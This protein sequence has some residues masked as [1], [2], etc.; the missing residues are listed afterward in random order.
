MSDFSFDDEVDNLKA[1][2]DTEE[3]QSPGL[4]KPLAER[5]ALKSA[6][7]SGDLSV[8][9]RA[10][11][12]LSSLGKSSILQDA[13]DL[14]K[15]DLRINKREKVKAIL[16]NTELSPIEQEMQIQALSEEVEEQPKLDRSVEAALIED[17]LSNIDNESPAA[18]TNLLNYL[19]D[20]SD[21]LQKTIDK[22]V[23]SMAKE[24]DESAPW[25]VTE[26][27]VNSLVPG[28]AIHLGKAIDQAMPGVLD[29]SD[30]IFAGESLKKFRT[31]MRSK[32]AEERSE[33]A[34]KLVK[35]LIDNTSWF[36]TD[37]LAAVQNIDMIL[38][39]L[40]PSLSE[41]DFERWLN[42]LFSVLDVLPGA[43]AVG[44][45]LHGK[46][47]ARLLKG[48]PSE[49][50]RKLS[51]V[52][53]D[54]V[55]N[56]LN[57]SL[58]DEEFEKVINTLGMTRQDVIDSYVL[59][60]AAGSNIH[61]GPTLTD[62]LKEDVIKKT[63]GAETFGINYK[64]VEK[65]SSQ[66][67]IEREIENLTTDLGVERLSLTEIIPFTGG[68]E[69]RVAISASNT[70]GFTSMD[71]ARAVALKYLETLPDESNIQYFKANHN[72]GNFD[73]VSPLS[74][75]KGQYLFTIALKHHYNPK[76][77]G[78]FHNDVTGFT[79]KPAAY[80][81]MSSVFNRWMVHAINRSGDQAEV[82]KAELH[83]ILQPMIKLDRKNQNVLL[84]VLD[85][86]DANQEWFDFNTLVSKLR[87][88]D[89]PEHKIP[90]IVEGYHA[91]IRFSNRTHELMND[92]VRK[93]LVQDG[94]KRVLLKT[95]NGLEDSIGKITD[96]AS[97]P[98]DVKEV[99]VLGN[100]AS[101][102]INTRLDLK[103]LANQG[104][105]FIKL[106]SPKRFPGANGSYHY[107]ALDL[108][109]EGKILK[110]P[111]QVLKRQE[112]YVPR[113]YDA[114]YIVKVKVKGDTVD[115][116][117]SEHF[118]TL[119]IESNIGD[120]S[121]A[122]D[123]L[124]KRE[125][126]KE[127]VYVLAKEQKDLEYIS[128]TSLDYFRDSGRLF[129][130]R[131]TPTEFSTFLGKRIVKSIGDSYEEAVNFASKHVAMD[132]LIKSM[133]TRWENTY[134]NTLP[135]VKEFPYNTKDIPKPDNPELHRAWKD[136]VAIKDRINHLAGLDEALSDRIIN[137]AINYTATVIAG[138]GKSDIFNQI[139]AA[140]LK[141][142]KVAN[143]IKIAKNLAF[144]R[145]IVLEPQKQIAMQA[146][147]ASIM[148][149]VDYGAKYFL[150]KGMVDFQGLAFGLALDRKGETYKAI[151]P[152]LAK[153]MGMSV[154]DYEILVDAFKSTGFKQG[155]RSHNFL[156]AMAL[157][158]RI[159]DDT[160]YGMPR[161]AMNTA[162][163]VLR[164]GRK[165]FE[166]G[167]L[168]NM[169]A[170]FLAAR[171]KW[172]IENKAV[173]NTYALKDNLDKIAATARE[174]TFNM[175][176]VGSTKLQKGGLGM[177]FQ[178]SSHAHKSM[179]ALVPFFK[180]SAFNNREKTRIA[181]QQVALFGTTG[182]FGLSAAVNY[183]RDKLGIVNNPETNELIETGFV[184]SFINSSIN[185]FE[186]VDD[187]SKETSINTSR[188]LAPLQ[189]LD[190]NSAAPITKIATAI[191]D[192]ATRESITFE[193][194][195]ALIGSNTGPA[196]GTLDAIKE[197]IGRSYAIYNYV[198]IPEN[199]DNGKLTL[200]LQEAVKL[201]PIFDRNYQYKLWQSTGHLVNK[202]NDPIVAASLEEMVAR[203]IFGTSIRDEREVSDLYD[204]LKGNGIV[205]L[206]EEYNRANEKIAKRLY[207][208]TL[209]TFKEVMVGDYR[210]AD[211][212]ASIESN[213]QAL[214]LVYGEVDARKIM[215]HFKEIALKEHPIKVS[216]DISA[217]GREETKEEKLQDLVTKLV[218]DSLLDAN[219]SFLT[220]LRNSHFINEEQR[221]ELEGYFERGLVE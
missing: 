163:G 128:G 15:E 51:I 134:V 61:M 170:A 96:I 92:K 28:Y 108:A 41:I 126:N 125:P 203:T 72:T 77:T 188:F 26:S 131:R 207:D 156:A 85:E 52:H 8:Y 17:R 197:A 19:E 221:V 160:L 145:H 44:K 69:A 81:D 64:E 123:I 18:K 186:D 116:N 10:N 135:G 117:P 16:E 104:L 157:D 102:K 50:L 39:D 195:M 143:P 89:V 20:K 98:D 34:Q 168:I 32:T 146:S 189:A 127:F 11:Q 174:L 112:G 206:G 210:A 31:A 214:T 176:E 162:K 118:K 59:P 141:G 161:A 107:V 60:R 133:V 6:I 3:Q 70:Q 187:E 46:V 129:T 7:A 124:R 196:I 185:L 80:M 90:E 175:S 14:D 88:K 75:G 182:L 56:T 200:I 23:L 113:S 79:G 21:S 155:V 198:K 100:N 140:I 103:S 86:G 212:M 73:P 5:Y 120:A 35:G 173:G 171:N 151:A 202:L 78:V 48:A 74:K 109:T 9:Q 95:H 47:V 190:K 148:L 83:G 167:E 37:Q 29:Y 71:E 45:A 12:E 219:S 54:L 217:R 149:G 110:L 165:G 136:A 4:T 68:F 119:F 193:E 201:I 36:D 55:N 204:D 97:I 82:Y 84:N 194:A 42:N 122:V 137:N 99:F 179:N 101:S 33:I 1:I 150:G 205:P 132:D 154:K 142:K 43:R 25:L 215:Q 111:S 38:D 13:L 191:V 58:V 172:I 159:G 153:G 178:F 211:I 208:H 121:R 209:K 220:K 49:Q 93:G 139:S 91:A 76:D 53:P 22:E 192:I 138:S 87:N 158:R 147:T 199:A 184:N 65:V 106:E 130:S 63:V 40:D 105:T 94:Y 183:A 115:G 169:M 66:N 164:F 114:A 180:G 30:Y 181:L 213:R 57:R 67:K 27:F 144:I 177:F 62:E 2:M 152:H 218:N 166:G 216:K 24:Q